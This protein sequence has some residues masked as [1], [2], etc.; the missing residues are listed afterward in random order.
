MKKEKIW[1]KT[2]TI[3]GKNKNLYRR[4][5]NGNELYKSSIN[6]FT[7]KGSKYDHKKQVSLGETNH[8]NNLH[9]L[10]TADNRAKGNNY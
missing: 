4:D 2:D 10:K 6:K 8:I 9:L 5:I 7:D 1:A 3:P